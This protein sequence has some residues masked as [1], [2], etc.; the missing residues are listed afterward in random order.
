MFTNGFFTNYNTL[1]YLNSLD[2][3]LT[4]I[5]V[6]HLGLKEGN[7]LIL[8]HIEKLGTVF[9]MMSVYL[10][11]CFAMYLLWLLNRW[12]IFE[13]YKAYRIYI[14]ALTLL[15]LIVVVHWITEILF[16]LTTM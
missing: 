4:S 1:F 10:I 3:I 16:T 6:F 12:G 15:Y 5:G 11:T 2:K 13:K 9:G 7:P 8:Y 14:F